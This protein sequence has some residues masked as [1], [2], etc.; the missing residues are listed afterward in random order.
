MNEVTEYI[1]LGLALVGV[2]SWLAALTPSKKDDRVM[3][4]VTAVLDIVGGN[5]R[6]AKNRNR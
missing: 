6:H 1:E 5:W 3:S 4:K 2:A